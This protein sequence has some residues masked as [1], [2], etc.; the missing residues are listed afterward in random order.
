M[1]LKEQYGDFV[2]RRKV[3]VE[4]IQCLVYEIEHLPTKATIL[5]LACDDDE[6]VFCLS[7]RTYPPSSNGV[8]HI[9]E[10][11]VLCGS[12]KY[13]IQDPFFEMTRRSLNTFMNALTGS[14][15]TCYPAASTLPKDFYNL[16][17]VYTDAV[18]H[19]NLQRLSFLQEGHRLEYSSSQDPSSPLIYK[20]IVF[21]EMKGAMAPPE[22]RLGEALCASLYP[23]VP[24]G[25]NSGGDPKKIPELTYEGLSDFHKRFY[26]PGHCLF[27]FYGNLPIKGH[28]D[29]LSENV[30]RDVVAPPPLALLPKQPRFQEKKRREMRYPIAEGESLQ[31]K[32]II[33]MGWL[34][35]SVLDVKTLLALTLI[36]LVLMGTDAGLLKMPLLRSNLAHQVDSSIDTEVSEVPYFLFFKG[37]ELEDANEIEELVRS[38]L[39]EICER[40]L[41][42]DL[43]EGAIHQHELA[44]SEITGGSSPYGL[45]LFMRSALSMQ[46]G[47]QPEDGL[48]IHSLF[49]E[50]RKKVKDPQ[51]LPSIIKSQLLDNLH[52]VRIDMRPDGQLEAQEK[53]EEEERLASI[54]ESL[55]REASE[56][57]LQD[58]KELHIFQE[59]EAKQDLEC[60]PK[61]TLQDVNRSGK[62]FPLK[63][64]KVGNLTLF[65][66]DCFTNQMVY[67]DLLFDLPQVK[68]E[69]LPLV[70]L[71]ALFL[72]QVGSNG[73]S[74]QEHLHYLLE[75]T[76][77]VG[78]SL[79]LAV[80]ATDPTKMRPSIA[81][82]GRALERKA[83]KLFPL[84]IDM[85][86]SAN[87]LDHERIGELLFQHLEG[88][89]SSMPSY[90]LRY[91]MN[92]A[93]APL[94]IPGRVHLAWYGLEYFHF[95]RKCAMD[96]EKDPEKLGQ[97][98]QNLQKRILMQG[99]GHLILSCSQEEL[100]RLNR[101]SFFG[102][103]DLERSPAS[104]WT[105]D[106]PLVEVSSQ[107]R[108]ISAPVAFNA[109]VFEG[110]AFNHPDNAVLSVCTEIMENCLLHKRIREQGGAY[111]G[112]SVNG[113]VSGTFSFYSYR[114]PHIRSTNEAFKEATDLLAEGQFDNHDLESAKLEVI[115]DLDSPVPPRSRA[116]VSYG[117]WRGG[118]SFEMREAFRQTLLDCDCRKVQETAKEILLPRLKKATS[119][120]FAGKEL[121]EQEGIQPIRTVEETL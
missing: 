87:F 116:I 106:L 20:G 119:I 109:C 63:I 33:G 21:N 19:P 42:E 115:Q 91:A 29:F 27:Y 120:S 61:V 43:V 118:R 11:T 84:Y 48:R 68:P 90:A 117:R 108:I 4:E 41:P 46:H 94:S 93:A 65:H 13:P 74:Y 5:H 17:E 44:R 80:Q 72:P 121:L 3:S 36:D 57:I 101:E 55:T 30:F 104:P 53:A 71:L 31:K 9:L 38:T 7:F 18:F 67:A 52:F 37:C 98:L 54:K 70:R 26:H 85:L 86:S 45:S 99:E 8:A 56:K 60:L 77:G 97:R 51:Y 110:V 23:D 59:Q 95:I 105:G 28:L 78:C 62:E 82:R 49:D 102:L 58:S 24:Y 96:F 39:E 10:H 14:D 66:H 40:G 76:G 114:D 75:H 12:K 22:A 69:E 89:E 34:T 92:L 16:L 32:G 103:G 83:D 47:G 107:G 73:R 79:D 111:G 113:T 6:N 35:C 15:F 2:V 81:L 1:E 112:G 88:L 64:E 25:Y 50:M 100:Q